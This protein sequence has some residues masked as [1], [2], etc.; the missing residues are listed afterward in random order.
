[1]TTTP[2]AAALRA[3]RAIDESDESEFDADQGRRRLFNAALIDAATMLP[4]MI[5]A[6]RSAVRCADSIAR[7]EASIVRHLGTSRDPVIAG[8]ATTTFAGWRRQLAH[9]REI[10][11][12]L[13]NH[14]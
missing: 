12:K 10:L 2:T 6:L 9:A 1:M 4:E 7:N 3:A 5:E 14:S 8:V 13:E 11:Q